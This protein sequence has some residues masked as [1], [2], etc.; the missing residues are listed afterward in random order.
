M[1]PP[2]P[3]SSSFGT[4]VDPMGWQQAPTAAGQ[5]AY[6]QMPYG[7]QPG[8]YMAKP[9]RP[10][11]KVGALLVIVGSLISVI[12]VFLPWIT[13][14]GASANGMDFFTDSEF[15]IYDGPGKAAIVFAVI[16]GSLGIALFFAGRVLAVAI[17]AI[18][19]ATV[20]LFVGIFLIALAM[21]TADFNPDSSVAVGAILQPIAPLLTLAGA[22]VA[23]STR[24]RWRSA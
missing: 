22:I 9:P 20:A 10:A 6:G 4:P 18:V 8:A 19:V 15:T 5:S 16:T 7:G 11:V 24:R 17:V 14:G 13:A 2:A 23:T 12:G 21:D 1:P 3:A